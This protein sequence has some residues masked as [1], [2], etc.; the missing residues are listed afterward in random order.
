M[1]KGKKLYDPRKDSTSSAYD[2]SLGVSTHRESDPATWQWSNNSAL[3]VRDYVASS[4]GLASTQS[5]IDEASFAAAATICDQD[6][7]LAAGGT[8]KRYTTNGPFLT[9]E[10]PNEIILELVT[11]M[12]GTCHLYPSDAGDDSL[13]VDHRGR[14]ST[15]KQIHTKMNTT[16]WEI[17]TRAR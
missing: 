11:A 16:G 1:V 14:P 12:A 5:E 3:C 8:E 9:S 4:Y 10:K 15:H 7:T 17:I 13:R 2:S 6:I